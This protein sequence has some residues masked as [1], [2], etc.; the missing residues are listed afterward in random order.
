MAE[1]LLAFIAQAGA[2]S[3]VMAE[4]IIGCPMKKASTTR[5]PPVRLVRSGQDA[6]AG[7]ASARTKEKDPHLAKV[8]PFKTVLTGDFEKLAKLSLRTLEVI[9][10][11]TAHWKGCGC[12][13]DRREVLA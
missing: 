1:E 8:E 2:K 12:V 13:P 9:R 4:G 6:S 11:A 10:A 3:V 5:V 7:P